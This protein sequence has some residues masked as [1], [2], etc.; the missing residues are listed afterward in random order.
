MTQHTRNRLLFRWGRRADYRLTI[1]CMIFQTFKICAFD[2]WGSKSCGM[3]RGR[4]LPVLAAIFYLLPVRLLLQDYTIEFGHI[5][6]MFGIARSECSQGTRLIVCKLY[7]A[8]AWSLGGHRMKQFTSDSAYRELQKFQNIILQHHL[9]HH[10]L[11]IVVDAQSATL[12]SNLNFS[13][14][15]TLH[16]LGLYGHHQVLIL[17]CCGNCCAHRFYYLCRPIYVLV[18]L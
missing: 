13:K 12:Y 18:Y 9:K 10:F 5:T 15:S 8:M 6:G 1:G 17:L 14:S 11:S 4:L 7:G 2:P 16:V 3:V